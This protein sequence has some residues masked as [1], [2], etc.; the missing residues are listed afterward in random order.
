MKDNNVNKMRQHLCYAAGTFGHDVFYAILATYFMIFVTSN[1][2]H[3]EDPQHDAYMIGIITTVIMV[4]RI[5]E[6]VIDPVI[7]NLIDKTKTR[8]GKFKPW[9]V[10]GSIISVVAMAACYTDLGGLTANPVIYTII[11]AALYLIMDI[12][13]SAKDVAIWSMI[14]ALTFDSHE[15]DIT[16]SFARIG[17]VFGGQLVGIMVMPIV[18]YFSLNPNGGA[19]DPQG[20]FAFAVIGGSIT[21]LGAII[22]ALGTKEQHSALRENKEDTP[23]SKVFSVLLKNDQLLWI[24]CT[25]LILGLG[26]NIVYSLNLYY[27]VYVIGA[28]MQFS[29]LGV[30]NLVIGLAGVSLFPALAKK[31]SRRRLF[32][33]GVAI[34]II[35][36]LLYAIAG[37]S[38]ILSLIA[39][40]LFNLPGAFLFLVVLMTITDS[41]E[42]G[43]LK[44]GHRDEALV[45]CVR[46]LVDKIS[47]AIASGAI[48]FVAVWVGMTS[49]ASAESLTP[50]NI[51]N[52]HYIMFGLPIVL[53]LLGSL[54]YKNK[55]TLDEKKHEAIVA[56]LE[57]KWNKI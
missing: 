48:G 31:F 42:Y 37:K 56:E 18:L 28:P 41:V 57:K 7:G 33:A 26:Q 10:A 22:L 27:F 32:F 16:A 8:W 29:Y 55:V 2:F 35:A 19:G 40:G 20:W 30:I 15:R 34:E 5:V 39:A 53:L 43:Q 36:L 9:I 13:F 50:D 25:W 38:V 47:G 46:P 44:S 14:P 49:G 6:V 23:L 45:L 24:A 4:L 17:S 1:L 21:I 11:F 52:L 3:S 54:V 51:K 12:F